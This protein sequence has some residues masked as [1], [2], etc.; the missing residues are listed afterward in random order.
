MRAGTKAGPYEATSAIAVSPRDPLR[1][2][3]ALRVILS[4]LSA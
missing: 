1:A 4:A 3:R 2:L